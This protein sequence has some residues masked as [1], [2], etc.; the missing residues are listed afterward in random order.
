MSD[1]G[2]AGAEDRRFAE[3]QARLRP[4]ADDGWPGE[5]ERT[6]VVCPSLD[7]DPDML[8]RHEQT[9][10]AYE[11]RFLYLLFMLKRPGIRIVMLSSQAIPEPILDYYLGLVPAPGNET[12]RE[13]LT[14][15]SA[16]RGGT[17]PLAEKVLDDPALIERI[18][19]A[20]GG[21]EDA[22]I[23]PYMVRRSE[24]D[25]A[26]ALGLPVYC[27]DHRFERFGTKVGSRRLFRKA[28]VALP[29][30]REEIG[31]REQL[32]D[33]IAELRAEPDPPE[34]LVVKHN[35]AVYGEGNAILRLGDLPAPGS[36]EEP[37]ALA[38]LV[39]SLGDEYLEKLAADPGIVE[40]LVPGE[41]TSPSAQVRTIA[42]GEAGLVS[43]HDQ[44]L[45]GE[46]GQTF[47]GASF[48][49]DRAYGPAIAAEAEQLR[50]RM[51]ELGVVGRFGVDFVCA[52]RADGWECV[53]IEINLREG[54]TTH[55][56]GALYF[57]TDA[58]Y[59]PSSGVCTTPEGDPK[60]YVASDLLVDER[61][62]G[63][64]ATE[65]IDAVEAAG[66]GWDAGAGRGA[67][68]HMLGSLE[69]EG[70][71][72]ATVIADSAEQA[73]ADYGRLQAALSDL[74]DARAQR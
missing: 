34:A 69:L 38:E 4:L 37:A 47:T 3:I 44:I 57:L 20:A 52:R 29:P 59:D 74:A 1:G 60:H 51:S 14:L 62:I 68:L 61:L 35:D 40:E 56:F 22:F 16:E 54:G 19:S 65:V 26:L 33:A 13:R 6:V 43:T 49:A 24:R 12:A 32:R 64:T 10:D 58:R 36:A 9:L 53:A 8:A 50:S 30:G 67:V 72:G 73:A 5:P 28:G 17:S 2:S 18:R 70:K 39:D 21:P 66:L 48:P 63:C 27:P 55:P 45:G 25:L 42:D 23:A 31:T 15:I 41:I 7:V 71:C 11:Q 46:H